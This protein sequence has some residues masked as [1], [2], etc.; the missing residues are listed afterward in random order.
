M[1]K[2]TNDNGPLAQIWLASNMTN[3]PR[4]SVLQTNVIESAKEIAEVAGC[5][6]TIEETTEDEDGNKYITLR[7]SGEL[8]QGIGQVYAKQAGF[9]LSDIKDILTKISSLFKRSSRVG[10]TINKSN[11]ITRIE[12]I[13]LEDTVTEKEVL[14]T[15][16]LD[17]LFESGSTTIG[18][19]RRRN[20]QGVTMGAHNAVWD[21]SIEV[22]RQN[23]LN[24]ND[25]SG[26]NSI[27]DLNFDIGE[28]QLEIGDEGTRN[29]GMNS[30]EISTAGIDHMLFHQD[31][32]P[33]IDNNLENNWNLDIGDNHLEGNDSSIELGRRAE[34]S[35][36]EEEH[37][38]FGFDLGLEK[39]NMMEGFE[40]E[41]QEHVQENSNTLNLLSNPR[42][43]HNLD[44]ALIDTGRII[45]D[46]D[47]VLSKKELH[48]VT[49]NSQS[50]N[51]SNTRNSAKSITKKRLW[52][53]IEN[54]TSYINTS[55]TNTLIRYASIKKPRNDNEDI[56][57]EEVQLD[58]NNESIDNMEMINDNFDTLQGNEQGNEEQDILPGFGNMGLSM[59]NET[60]G[61][62]ENA[63]ILDEVSQ[64]SETPSTIVLPDQVRLISGELVSKDTV[65]MAATLRTVYEKSNE[66]PKVTF[67]E[68][69]AKQ[70]E[71]NE[72]T[73][74]NEEMT[75]SVQTRKD[76]SQCF[77]DM[78][79][80]ASAGCVS[81]HQEAPFAE[82]SLTVEKTINDKFIPE[83][84]E[85]Q[86]LA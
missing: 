5:G 50:I 32:D 25:Y 74:N 30:N 79:T 39:E 6:D 52:N 78:L 11:T 77:F 28:D 9:L 47:R 71:L 82:I 13:T 18:D 8:L 70:L 85:T 22:G 3:I 48:D 44:P 23:M 49:T 12:S 16:S 19:N 58:I 10:I 43:P 83:N 40:E 42:R 37:T 67:P 14:L 57:E 60:P 73:T 46:D 20:I 69:L 53:E 62:I 38:E 63:R 34:S 17:F 86:V 33:L 36:L 64:S 2:L 56:P 80:L 75:D 45:I 1:L 59:E 66:Y 65:D 15:P 26:N 61:E 68:L 24:D 29:T 76:A 21:T 81:L 54:D 84:S 31:D 55:I 51:N 72:D 41:V 35:V 7:T 27:L 4:G